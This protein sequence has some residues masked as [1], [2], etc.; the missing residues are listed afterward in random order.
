VIACSQC[1][2]SPEGDEGDAVPFDWMTD[3]D[4]GRVTVVCPACAR[5]HS[6]AIEGKLD[7]AWW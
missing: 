6:R 7:Q 2:R 1:G 3:R 4:R 5:Q